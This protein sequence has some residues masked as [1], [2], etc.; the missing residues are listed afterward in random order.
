[1]VNTALPPDPAGS[2]AR[3]TDANAIYNAAGGKDLTR[4]FDFSG[5]PNLK[6]VRFG[7]RSGLVAG[8]L[9][10]IPMA[11][12]TFRPATSPRLSAI[13][14]D[15]ACS[16]IVHPPV[17]ILIQD[18]SHDLRWVAN[19]VA[20]IERE[21]EGGVELVVRRDSGFA[22]VLDTLNVRFRLC[23]VRPVFTHSLQILRQWSR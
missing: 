9:I 2:S 11:L 5:F 10:W 1:M 22:T 21:F 7:F 18:L 15:F 6:E 17:N 19:E 12:S 3:N 20:R 23:R 16:P 13:R 8:G 14:L 4:S